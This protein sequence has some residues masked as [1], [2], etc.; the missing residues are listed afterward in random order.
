MSKREW[1]V[2]AGIAGA[3]VVGL[4][5]EPDHAAM[6]AHAGQHSTDMAAMPAARTVTLAVSGMT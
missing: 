4:A 1:F 5:L 2:L 6:S 3:V